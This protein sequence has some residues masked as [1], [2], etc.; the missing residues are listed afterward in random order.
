M[1]EMKNELNN[2]NLINKKKKNI[3]FQK[4]IGLIIILILISITICCIGDDSPNE[5]YDGIFTLAFKNGVE[6]TEVNITIE[7]EF[8]ETI[9]TNNIIVPDLSFHALDIPLEKGNY[10]FY[11]ETNTNLTLLFDI[12]IKDNMP[13]GDYLIAIQEGLLRE[14]GYP[15]D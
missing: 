6:S 3:Y 15:K 14:V 7:N 13:H 11:L 4:L 1:S 2:K 8:N 12:K 9:Y 10:L 5:K